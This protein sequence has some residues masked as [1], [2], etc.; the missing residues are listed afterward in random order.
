MFARRER[1]S[2]QI[3]VVGKDRLRVVK[4]FHFVWNG[5]L[6]YSILQVN[7]LSSKHKADKDRDW[8]G[9]IEQGRFRDLDLA[10]KVGES[11]G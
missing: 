11:Y 3:I 10:R 9:L 6:I 7:M 4:R 1:D 5:V 8:I 2:E